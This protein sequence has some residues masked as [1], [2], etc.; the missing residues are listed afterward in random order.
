MSER[1][2]SGDWP[3][4]AP[5]VAPEMP[6]VPGYELLAELGRGGMGVVYKAR[7][8][9]SGRLVALKLIRDVALAGRQ[10]RARFRIEMQAAARMR[11][12]NIVE[13]FEAGEHESRPY[14]AMEYV[15]GGALDKHLAGQPQPPDQAAA[16]VRMLAR[17]VEHAHAQQVIHRDLKP[18]N[19]L[20][21][22]AD[23]CPKITDFGLAKRLDTESTAWTQ[24]GAVIGTASYMAPEQAAGRA[25][26][27]A[28][29]A[30][31]YALGAILYECLTGRPPFQ[32]DSVG[33]TI[34]LV[35]NAEP[36][37]PTRLQP[38]VPRDLE[39]LCLKCLEK[40]PRR[41]YA[42]A[43]EL[44]D[45]LDRFLEG[46]PIAAVPPSA[47][48]RLTRMAVRDGYA[49]VDEIGRGPRSTVYRAVHGS[50]GQPV[51]LK[52]F[53][54]ASWTRDAWDAQLRSAAEVRAML[55]HPQILPIQQAGW[56]DDAP[57]L[58]LEYLPQ[59]SLG[60]A[61]AGKPYGVR[62]ALRMLEQLAEIVAYLHRQGIVHGNLKPSNV[63]LAADGIPR[64]ADF[65]LAGGLCRTSLPADDN[66]A[67]L[68]YLAPELVRDP[69]AEVRFYTDIYGL[70]LI[71]YELL[72]GQP[73]FG[74]SSAQATLAQVQSQEPVPPSHRNS[75]IPP[76]VDTF[77]L[78]CLHKNPWRRYARAFD[79]VTL[80]R[81]LREHVD[82]GLPSGERWPMRHA[83]M[84]Q[85]PAR[86]DVPRND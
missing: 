83:P 24:D 39:T 12:A 5:T 50:V 34:E 20:L 44:A 27:V 43:G 10:E 18:A 68:G 32:A 36:A 42:S 2:T 54:P 8:A 28:P 82:A 60:G 86:C 70:G 23:L 79:V 56:W 19:I 41:R 26:E 52:V 47:R 30:D 65:R 4:P 55:A 22:G 21:Q 77:C 7:Q 37:P 45:D 13:V 33:R 16:L 69:G 49:I 35:L 38:A 59:G 11:H 81:N 15:D 31:V 63:L 29:A 14:F 61:L 53:Q 3:A 73:P 76:P 9:S 84:R 51:A 17:A 75:A 58:V 62:E 46:T 40:E 71:L 72:T 74:E 1:P 64:V 78:R 48:E 85:A 57:Y 6:V 66:P 25:H 67:G 80:A